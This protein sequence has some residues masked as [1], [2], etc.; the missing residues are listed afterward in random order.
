MTTR[1]SFLVTLAGLPLAGS[2]LGAS[3][4]A[5]STATSISQAENGIA[6]AQ[7]VIALI[8]TG[9]DGY[10]AAKPNPTLQGQIDSG[11][12]DTLSALR[13]VDTALAGATSLNDAN[14]QAAI[15]SFTTAFNA[16]ATLVAQIGVQVSAA[17]P[18]GQV[19]RINGVLNIAPPILLSWATK[20]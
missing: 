11:I 15:G 13:V 3:C 8:Q 5:V 4:N 12:G 10:F 14:V 20:K 16:L 2:Q 1:R 9:V 6:D 7:L 17:A 19:V 18:R